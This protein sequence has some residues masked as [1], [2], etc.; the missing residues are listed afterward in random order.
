MAK[1]FYKYGERQPITYVDWSEVGKNFTDMLEGQ[2]A[3]RE[4]KKAEIKKTMDEQM[5]FIQDNPLGG[6]TGNDKFS[7]NLAQAGQ[8]WHTMVNKN[9]QSGL[10]NYNDAMF[11]TQNTTKQTEKFYNTIKAYNARSKEIEDD[12]AS[13]NPKISNL[14]KGQLMTIEGLNRFDDLTPIIDMEGN[15]NAVTY[16]IVDG[17]QVTKDSYT[18]K[19]LE[20]LTNSNIGIFDASGVAKG[21]ADSFGKL[22][23][24]KFKEALYAG[25]MGLTITEVN[26]YSNAKLK[27]KFSL[28]SSEVDDFREYANIYLQ[29]EEDKIKAFMNPI[30]KGSLFVDFLE[31]DGY[32][33]T[34]NL[35]EFESQDKDG[36]L[37]FAQGNDIRTTEE[38]DKIFMEKM[39]GL[40]R[41]AT[42][43][44]ITEKATSRR[45]IPKGD[46]SPDKDKGDKFDINKF[47]DN[48]KLYSGAG[49]Q[50]ELDGIVDAVEN[51]YN[52]R[53]TAKKLPRVK[54]ERD[55]LGVYA[56]YEDGSTQDFLFYDGYNK[57]LGLYNWNT[58][59]HEAFG[60]GELPEGLRE[61]Y[62]AEGFTVEGGDLPSEWERSAGTFEF[63]V[64]P[65]EEYNRYIQAVA[66]DGVT[67]P[68]VERENKAAEIVDKLTEDAGIPFLEA[69]GN[70][71]Y[72]NIKNEKLSKVDDDYKYEV[73]TS[74]MRRL[75][76]DI[77]NYLT[78][79]MSTDDD[80]AA[81]FAAENMT[82]INNL[83]RKLEAQKQFDRRQKA[84]QARL[85][86]LE[87][88]EKRKA[89]KKQE[90]LLQ[91][92]IDKEGAAAFNQD[93]TTVILNN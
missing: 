61:M 39:K 82:N 8:E 47:I 91:K 13:G 31:Q 85:I 79:R 17:K 27:E 44:S 70:V 64:T 9:M 35:K 90:A 88:E 65:T 72:F 2:V 26:N 93:S 10:I 62:A 71:I 23:V 33:T 14:T 30:N 11:L 32:Q 51:E 15:I 34:T 1:T 83:Y 86:A 12:I 89:L 22:T 48:G 75:E 58:Q 46:K 67:V 40:V 63:E 68:A 42:E 41:T 66:E 7:F 78:R 5:E 77:K 18:V 19:Q 87:E 52:K 55:N 84:E 20:L 38:Q 43:K 36:K 59:F 81:G 16:D 4:S 29:A 21:I 56:V 24:S 69:E 45:A 50:Q 92:L 57:A 49:T 73:G 74:D 80:V 37:V 3:A 53:A 25:G 60:V 76:R 28:S 6:I 54:L